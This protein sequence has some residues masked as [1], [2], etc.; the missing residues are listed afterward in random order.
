MLLRKSHS[1]KLWLVMT[2]KTWTCITKLTPKNPNIQKSQIFEFHTSRISFKNLDS[3][4]VLGPG[5]SQVFQFQQTSIWFQGAISL[6]LTNASSIPGAEVSSIG[7]QRLYIHISELTT[8]KWLKNRPTLVE[9]Y[10]L[11]VAIVY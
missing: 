3:F 10:S 4:L 9:T 6:Q 7:N 11:S 1:K 5:Q 2:E 8:G